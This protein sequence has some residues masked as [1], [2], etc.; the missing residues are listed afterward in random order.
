MEV[1]E[2]TTLRF[3]DETLHARRNAEPLE[4]ARD[5]LVARHHR[6]NGLLP[7][8]AGQRTASS[9]FRFEPERVDD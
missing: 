9:L 6:L 1:G 3:L 8:V 7:V 5:Q 2:Q 4:F